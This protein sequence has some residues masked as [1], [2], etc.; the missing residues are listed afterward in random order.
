[1]KIG[2][3]VVKIQG[4][5]YVNPH[6]GRSRYFAI[7][8]ITPSGYNILEIIENKYADHTHGKG[9]LVV[10]LLRNKGVEAVLV[11]GIGHGAFTKL[12]AF[13]IKIYVVQQERNEMIKL[14]DT[15][16]KLSK[17]ML[18]EANALAEHRF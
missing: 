8:E 1:M 10:D 15:M 2:V 6:F 4:E 9:D 11:N 18:K 12:N 7:I 5:F 17:G 14:K 3:P 13:G 16:E